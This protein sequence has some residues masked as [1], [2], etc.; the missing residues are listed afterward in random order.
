MSPGGARP[1]LRNAMRRHDLI[2]SALAT[3]MMAVSCLA[4]CSTRPDG[5]LDNEEAA[6][7]LA[8]L[9]IADTYGT[10]EGS[11]VPA[12]SA[13]SPDSARKVL[14]QSVLAK[15]GVSEQQLDTTLGWYGHNL[16]KYEE[17]YEM[18]LT[19]I[20]EKQK[21]LKEAE[22]RALTA[23]T[24]WPYGVT[25]RIPGALPG[26]ASLTPFDIPVEKLTKGGRVIWEGKTINLRSPMEMFMAVEYTDGST[27]YIQR[28]LTGEG[29]Q[30]VTLQT[31]TGAKPKRAYGYLRVSQPQA[32]FLDSVS[33]KVAPYNETSYYEIHS[34]RRWNP[35]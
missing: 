27:G 20:E 9:H 3:G 15:H 34:A 6:S 16:D 26:S 1:K 8:D 25:Q 2:F 13:D 29:R 21:T 12:V 17:M 5:V 10:L 7:L 18:V 31:D 32:L 24:L 33:L 19:K 30:T 35:K 28:T 11:A 23:A 14:R 4:G 22:T